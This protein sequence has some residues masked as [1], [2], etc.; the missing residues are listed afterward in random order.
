MKRALISR[1]LGIILLAQVI[2]F[3]VA[4]AQSPESSKF[5]LTAS[6][7]TNGIGG[8]FTVSISD[9][10][11]T[12]VGYH[13]FNYSLDGTISDTD[14]EIGYD[15]SLEMTSFS[16]M[17]DY[18][19]FK[20]FV[21]ISVGALLHSMT[22]DATAGPNASYVIGDKTFEADELGSLNAK[23]DYSGS[24]MPYAGLIF[25]NPVA[26][27]IPVKLHIQAGM[28]YSK[29]PSLEMTGTGMITPTADNQTSLQEGLDEF[30]FLPVVNVGFS[31]RFGK[32]GMVSQ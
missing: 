16:L 10:L 13:G 25:S 27:G 19:P 20:K 8:D 17:V 4:Q 24:L 22:V 23:I 30:Q 21:G 31:F 11:N 18:Y 1:I 6:A 12:R 15:G 9:Y 32:K 28:M 3:V 14:P 26:K 7:G 2:P 5:A 29:Q